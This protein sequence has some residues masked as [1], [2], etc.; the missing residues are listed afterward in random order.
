M[1]LR[2]S[3]RRGALLVGALALAAY[4]NSLANGFAYDDLILI[5]LNE[6]VHDADW[7]RLAGGPYW[8]ERSDGVGLYRPLAMLSYAMEWR[9]GGGSPLPFH[10]VNVALHAGVSLALFALLLRFAGASAAAAGAALFAVH[11][12]HVEAVANIVGRAELLAAL[13]YLA[14]CLLYLWAPE[15]KRRIARGARLAGL[16]LLYF[17]A[18]ASKEI[19]VT[20]PAALVL[21]D[22]AARSLRSGPPLSRRLRDEAASY[23]LLAVAFLAYL[24][25]RT[26]ALEG[27][28]GD[29]PHPALRELSTGPRLLTALAVWPEYL[30]LLLAPFDLSSDYSPAVLR[31]AHSLSAGVFAGA[32]VVAGLSAAA[33]AAR[34]RAPLISVAVA[35]FALAILPVSNLLMPIGVLLAERTLYL[36]SVGLALAV[37]HV[38]GWLPALRP[39]VRWAAAGAIVLAALAFLARTV[40][41]NPVWRDTDAMY[42]ALIAEH[43]ESYRALWALAGSMEVRGRPELAG[44]AFREALALAPDDYGLLVDA[45]RFL[46]RHDQWHEAER[47]LRHAI[48][49]RPELPRAYRILGL[50][51]VRRDSPRRAL[52][53][54]LEGLRLAR[55]TAELWTVVARAHAAA[56]DFGAA[57]R[58]QWT[59]L[60]LDGREPGEWL[61]LA[62]YLEAAGDPEGAQRARAEANRLEGEAKSTPNAADRW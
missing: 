49:V 34:R 9:A 15:A 22:L 18:L 25:L 52:V 11:P 42:D 3:P 21:L 58:A 28:V 37:T 55:W 26:L 59:A 50:Q 2:L 43:P 39:P 20:L 1:T 4:A 35:W 51:L 8:P 38:A 31:P 45:G 29:S 23:G 16:G 10:V 56:G 6:A 46:G 32:L 17:A 41:R 44:R 33:V 60:A 54:A 53:V 12:V 62:D 47:L 13:F 48:A 7:E 61:R 57:T 14:A 5:Q 40:M 36:P 19:A 30:R 27:L 24:G